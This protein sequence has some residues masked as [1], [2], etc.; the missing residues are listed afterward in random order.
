MVDNNKG[1]GQVQ[2]IVKA[3]A[4]EFFGLLNQQSVEHFLFA[5]G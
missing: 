1:L 4:K 5:K 2:E 3:I